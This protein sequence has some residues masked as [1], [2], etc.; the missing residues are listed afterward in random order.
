MS[1][2]RTTQEYLN[3][4][5]GTVGLTRQQALARLTGLPETQT[6]DILLNAYGAT[7]ARAGR[8]GQDAMNFKVG[9]NPITKDTVQEAV[10]RIA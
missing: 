7:S 2:N 4:R 3:A 8:G 1:T 10:S 6:M 5:A 9:S